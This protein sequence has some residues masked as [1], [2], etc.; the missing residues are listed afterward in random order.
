MFQLFCVHGM[1]VNG[2]QCHFITDVLQNIFFRVVYVYNTDWVNDD[3]IFKFGW[4]FLI[5]Q[6]GY[7]WI[8]YIYCIYSCWQD[9]YVYLSLSIS[10]FCL[11][12]FSIR[13]SFSLTD[14]VW[15][16]RARGATGRTSTV[17]NSFYKRRSVQHIVQHRI[18]SWPTYVLRLTTARRVW[19]QAQS[20][21]SSA[22]RPGARC[23]IE[24]V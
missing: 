9:R 5:T 22:N 15:W 24:A 10:W 23:N 11:S 3:R 12:Q 4:T 17:W 1:K 21:A 14:T 18:V 20:S 19:L 2:G 13:N 16:W 6:M 8:L 7:I